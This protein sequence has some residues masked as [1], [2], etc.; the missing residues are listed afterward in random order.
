MNQY[1]KLT[2]TFLVICITCITI[3]IITFGYGF[4]ID[5]HRT[6]ANYLLNNFY[7]LALAIGGAFFLAIQSITRSG[8]SAGFRRIPEAMM[9]YFPAAGILLL[10][11]YFGMHYLYHW[12]IPNSLDQS[13]EILHKTAYLNIPFF[14]VRLILFFIIWIILIRLI[15]KASLREDETDGGFDSFKK[16]EWYSRIFIF[17]L[18]FSFSLL[19]FDLLMSID[20]NWFS[21]IYALKNFIAAFQH[22]AVTIFIIVLLLNRNGYFEFLNRS[23]IHD[24]ARYIFILSIFY[25]Y[26]WFSQ[27]MLTWYA[28]IP[29]ETIYYA[30]RWT[31]EWQPLWLADIIINWCVPFF[32][33]LP[34]N[35]SR[36]KWIV[37]VVSLLLVA[38]QW[39]DLVVEIFPGSIGRVRFGFIEIGSYL[40]FAGLFALVIGYHLSKAALV[41]KNHPLIEESYKHHFESYI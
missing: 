33:L 16:I 6:W 40:G 26:F 37:L 8:W 30:V 14:F 24:F 9:M 32:V 39:V 19:C 27:F 31:P 35:T 1:I 7:F 25:G 23:H 34:V 11:L 41:P 22:G 38:G 5:P 28:N 18:A 3:G 4:I 36:N 29:D 12:S 21:T 15:R 13:K 20:V 10:F 2:K 17:V